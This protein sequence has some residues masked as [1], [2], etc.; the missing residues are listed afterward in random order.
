[1]TSE[2]CDCKGWKLCMYAIANVDVKRLTP[3]S[4]QFSKG[5]HTLCIDYEKELYTMS[6]V[7]LLLLTSA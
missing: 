2:I 1:M 3:S 4:Q 7:A 5:R 6:T